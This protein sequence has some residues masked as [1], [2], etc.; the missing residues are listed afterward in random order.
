MKINGISL[1]FDIISD[2]A[3][4]FADEYKYTHNHVSH[5]ITGNYSIIFYKND[6]CL[7]QYKSN[8]SRMN[9]IHAFK[10]FMKIIIY[11]LL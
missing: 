11:L 7:S 10:K 9:L 8:Y 2:M 5:F 1:N 4:R 3:K 6:S